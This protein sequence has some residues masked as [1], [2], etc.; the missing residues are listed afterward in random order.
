[1]RYIKF[2]LFI[3]TIAFAASAFAQGGSAEG[4]RLSREGVEAAKAKDWNKAVDSFR[5][6]TQVEPQDKKNSDNLEIALL[7]RASALLAQKNYDGAISDLNDALKIKSDDMA[8]HRSRGYAYL[9]KGDW[10]NA[11]AD[12]DIVVAGMKDDPEPHERRAYVQMQLQRF[13]AAIADYSEAIKLRP[14]EARY[15]GLRAYAYQ[16]KNDNKAAMADVDKVLQLDPA[17][18]DAQTRKRYL[19]AVLNPGPKPVVIPSGPIANPRLQQQQ[20]PAAPAPTR[21]P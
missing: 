6:A 19:E 11:L 20:S 16:Q 5:R 3:C 2:A 18:A 13:D 15:Y 17:N 12:Y 9:A 21:A 8:A 7:Q 4:A 10:N 1:M 14:K